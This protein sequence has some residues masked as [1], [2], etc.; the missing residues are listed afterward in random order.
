MSDRVEL[1]EVPM[2]GP[3]P[4][5]ES[6]IAA[7]R[8][9]ANA[10]AH[11]VEKPTPCRLCGGAVTEAEANYVG[12]WR[13]HPD[14]HSSNAWVASKLLGEAVSEQ[15]AV[16][17]PVPAFFRPTPGDLRHT[18]WSNTAVSERLRKPWGFVT[19]EQLAELDEAVT[20]QRVSRMSL[21]NTDERGCG[22]CGVREAL[23]WFDGWGGA[24]ADGGRAL[25][26]GVCDEAWDI[27]GRPA[28][29]GEQ[30]RWR[31][32]KLATGSKDTPM[33]SLGIRSYSE[34]APAPY[35]GT[36]EPWEY[37]PADT[38]NEARITLF[39]RKPSRAID[40][41]IGQAAARELH[42][43]IAELKRQQTERQKDDTLKWG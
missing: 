15:D 38:L 40:P 33:D 34:V 6:A 1:Y 20:E 28:F 12:G 8:R 22:W 24:F 27:A 18:G 35:E 3:K 10:D 13:Q 32:L 23:E 14:C 19:D 4:R 7:E 11:G 5:T 9:Y 37:I 21:P 26:C 43:R 31:V 42:A 41:E 2:D 16:E 30:W 17:V 29:Y 36:E 25:L 39:G